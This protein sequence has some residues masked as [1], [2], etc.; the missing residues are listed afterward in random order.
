MPETE[1]FDV[2]IVGG[3]INGCGTFRDLCAQGVKC[4]LLERDDFTAGASSASS[5]LMHGGLKYLETG[6]FRLVKESL[7]ERNM[8]LATAPHMVRP[9][10]CIVPVRSWGGGILGSVA[11]F[12]RLPGR[13]KDRGFLI[14][15]LGLT[16]YD[17][18]AGAWR[19][20]PRH[21]MLTRA[22]LR[23]EMPDLDPGIV[24]AGLYYEGQIAYAER[25]ALELVLDGEALE[26]RSRGLN[27]V[28]LLTPEGDAIVYREG[29]A[30]RR[31]RARVV[32]NA[33]GA[34]IDA[35]NARLGVPT[36]LI[37]GSKGSHLVVDNPA[38]HAALRGR[39]VYFGTADGR[40]NLVY[41]MLGRVLVGS[42]DIPVADPD[43]VECDET[44]VAYLRGAVAQVFPGIP[45]TEDQIV[46]RFCGVR[47]LPRADAADIGSVSRDHSIAAVALPGTAVPVFCLIGGKWTTFRAFSEQAADRALAELGMARRASTVGMPIGGGRDFPRE[48]AARAAMTAHMAR[49]AGIDP[50]RADTLLARY[51]TRA[52]AYCDSRAGKG[53]SM[54]ASLPDYARE[55]L[56]YVARTERARSLD[57]LLRR[58][59]A[60]ELC[61]QANAS[62][63]EELEELIPKPAEPASAD[64]LPLGAALSS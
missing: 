17:I 50:A 28:E 57:D 11:R 13:L 56:A 38:L 60:I 59:T 20:M 5:R 41:P 26:P 19:A 1:A 47:P 3:G 23:K 40:V 24:G 21:R 2:V 45:V 32:I 27:H 8:L 43:A 31:A 63:R 15:A 16:L 61:G 58:R 29:G 49:A 53:E 36:T 54:L 18:Y 9:L 30:T 64:A 33:A 4:L 55:E 37:G 46:Y 7:T 14:T 12:L 62:L 10:P 44:E 25:L 6:E 51:G 48:P 39:M 34:W 52:R 22:A 35:V 42:T